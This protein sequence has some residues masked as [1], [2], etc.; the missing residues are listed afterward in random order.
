MIILKQLLLNIPHQSMLNFVDKL[1]QFIKIPTIGIWHFQTILLTSTKHCQD[2]TV[3][4]GRCQFTSFSLPPS[5][6][7]PSLCSFLIFLSFLPFSC[8]FKR[9]GCNPLTPPSLIHHRFQFGV[10]YLI[11]CAPE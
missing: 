7:F 3:Y 4:F 11:T 9:G 6:L 5:S 10:L 1:Q 2:Y 8:I